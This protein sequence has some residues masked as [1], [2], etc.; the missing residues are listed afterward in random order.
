MAIELEDAIAAVDGT[1]GNQTEIAYKLGVTPTYVGILKK[2]WA[3]FSEAIKVADREYYDRLKGSVFER[4][5]KSDKLAMFILNTRYG[6][7]EQSETEH[8]G[9]VK[10]IIEYEDPPTIG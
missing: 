4:A 1:W 6:W 10:I 9:A 3:T 5:L 8:V 2:R 7:K